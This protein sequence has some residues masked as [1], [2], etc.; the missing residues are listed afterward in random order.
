MC[1][2]AHALRLASCLLPA[3][4]V[5]AT[6]L[7]AQETST[8]LVDLTNSIRASGCG[9]RPGV[10][11]PLRPAAK[12][13]SVAAKVAGG[14][15]FERALTHSGYRASSAT[16]LHIEAMSGIGAVQKFLEGK[17]CNSVTD[18]KFEDIGI[19]RHELEYWI[20]LAAPLEF[21][22]TIDRAVVNE[23][24]LDLTNRARARKQK[25]GY[26]TFA[27]A[28]PL[29]ASAK[30]DAAAL[31]H[32]QD[33]AARNELT[34]TGHDGSSVRERVTRAGYAWQGVAENIAEGQPDAFVVVRDWLESPHH[35][36]NLMNPDYTQMGIGYAIGNQQTGQSYWVQVFARPPK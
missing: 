5:C 25:C 4:L 6:A 16:V 3:V 7:P 14:I 31:G 18:A 34:H 11:E 22:D 32:A 8:D 13:D 9:N 10:A 33:M 24:V 15:D 29:T 36:E 21:P 30:L 19:A 27:P 2:R 23:R 35:C 28:G 20:V 17:F 1:N 26:R 12:L